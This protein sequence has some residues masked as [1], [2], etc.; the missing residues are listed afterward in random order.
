MYWEIQSEEFY[1]N[2]AQILL[3]ELWREM[4]MEN[5]R[6]QEMEILISQM[7]QLP[8]YE[9]LRLYDSI[10]EAFFQVRDAEIR[11]MLLCYLKTAAEEI[12]YREQTEGAVKI[13]FYDSIA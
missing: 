3:E 4:E 1:R 9:L 2:D 7:N 10:K 13:V 6:I 12:A 5:H 11:D 8:I